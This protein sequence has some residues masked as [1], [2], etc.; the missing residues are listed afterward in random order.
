MLTFYMDLSQMISQIQSM[1]TSL[2]SPTLGNL[3]HSLNQLSERV[4]SY[5][6][7]QTNANVRLGRQIMALRRDIQLLRRT[8]TDGNSPSSVEC[9]DQ[10]IYVPP[11]YDAVVVPPDADVVDGQ[12]DQDDSTTM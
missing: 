9:T 3:F 1:M 5:E 10:V 4:K 7:S 11:V 2:F 8:R 12:D 6:E